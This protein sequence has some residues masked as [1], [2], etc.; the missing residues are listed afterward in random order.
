MKPGQPKGPK[1]RQS[2]IINTDKTKNQRE[3]IGNI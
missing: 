2:N 3:V 1:A